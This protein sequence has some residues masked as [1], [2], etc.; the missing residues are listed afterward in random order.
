MKYLNILTC[1]VMILFAAVQYNDPDAALWIVIYLVPAAWTGLA[2]FGMD[3]LRGRLPLSLL[4]LCAVLA[5]IGTIVYWPQTPGFWR[6][7]VWWETEAAREG[8]GMM[9]AT[10][11]IGVAVVTVALDAA[12]QRRGDQGENSELKI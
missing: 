10:L 11:A 7:D 3:R 4:G 9:A 1:A 8:M 12:G 2:A 6:I 5:V